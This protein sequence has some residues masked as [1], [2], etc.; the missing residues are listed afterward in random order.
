MRGLTPLTAT[1]ELAGPWC[2]SDAATSAVLE[3]V[4]LVTPALERFFIR[5]V[6]DCLPLADNAPELERLCREF[7]HEEAAHTGA[8]RKLNNALLDYMKR[9]PPGLATIEKLL[10]IANR[11][12][13][14]SSRVALV[15]ALEHFTAVL[16][17]SYVRHQ[18]R[19]RFN[20]A[21]ARDL[22]AE[23]A[24]EEIDHRSV[25]FDLWQHRGGGSVPVRFAAIGAIL[26]VGG[27]YLCAAAPW[28]LHRKNGGRLTATLA[29]LIAP[30]RRPRETGSTLKDLL[31]YLGRDYHPRQLVDD[32]QP[33]TPPG[34]NAP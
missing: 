22:F 15:A 1:A 16:S 7:I 5:T 28:I 26:F 13:S 34:R 29:A 21:Y 3:A 27:A 20:C 19:W 2:D 6:S 9:A 30:R 32:S 25:A 4:S 33:S 11:R 17:K 12:L 18:A 23:H 31:R 8:H 10:E 14:L 24:R